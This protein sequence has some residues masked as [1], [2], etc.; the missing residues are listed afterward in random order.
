MS[1]LCRQVGRQRAGSLLPSVGVAAEVRATPV[2]WGQVLL[3]WTRINSPRV[4]VYVDS[5]L[6]AVVTDSESVIASLSA[7]PHNIAVVAIN[8]QGVA[9]QYLRPEWNEG[10]QAL[11]RWESIDNASLVAYRVDGTTEVTTHTL[12]VS[13]L[14]RSTG[15][16]SGRIQTGGRFVGGTVNEDIVLTV[17]TSSRMDYSVQ[18]LTG[19]VPIATGETAQLPF[20]AEVTFLD[21]AADYPVTIRS[22]TLTLFRFASTLSF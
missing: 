6:Y 2:A 19:S 12:E 13:T 20:G 9:P 11:L 15:S 1:L 5:K 10:D 8:D 3:E 4:A 14:T 17:A 7:G 16:G 18:S 22:A 21:A